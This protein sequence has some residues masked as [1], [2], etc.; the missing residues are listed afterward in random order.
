M[1]K[2]VDSRGKPV[3]TDARELLG[4]QGLST[5]VVRGD[6][7]RDEQGN[8]TVLAEKVYVKSP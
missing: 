2:L 7:E 1:V 6:A 3:A 4:I 8:L 5:V